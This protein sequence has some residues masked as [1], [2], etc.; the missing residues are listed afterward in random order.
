M[1][2]LVGR[3]SHFRWF[4]SGDLQ[5]ADMLRDILAVAAR[6]TDTRHWFTTREVAFVRDALA[7]KT[8]PDNVVIRMPA[9]FPDSRRVPGESITGTVALVHAKQAPQADAWVCPA[10]SQGGKCG[11]CRACWSR[12]VAAVSYKAH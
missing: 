12:D 7:G 1:V 6:T 8:L 10:P 9:A 3:E 11:E 2:D 5:S 4:D